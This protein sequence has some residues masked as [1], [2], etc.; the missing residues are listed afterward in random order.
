[1][2]TGVGHF[3][4]ALVMVLAGARAAM[5]QNSD[6]AVIAGY[7][8]FVDAL[9]AGDAGALENLI[10][11]ETL[12]QERSRKIFID[13]ATA[14]KGL[15]KAAVSK[16]GVDGKQFRC[17][18]DLIVSAADRK[19]IAAAKVKY[20][21]GTR[22]A[23]IEKSGEL[24]PMDMRRRQD[25]QWQVILEVPGVESE[26]M[27]SFD[28]SN[29]Y[30]HPGAARQ[31]ALAGIKV[32]RYKAVIEAFIQTRARIESGDLAT[33]AAAAAELTGKLSAAAADAAKAAA[34]L[35]VGRGKD[36]P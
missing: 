28:P 30:L 8:K 23:R 9:E 6:A 32:A 29:P 16:F 5:A 27:D 34:A 4:A 18:F 20:E 11:A 26:E 19:A 3:L 15:E 17:G 10:C 21:E 33:A 2:K 13:L 22:M 36:R 12:P 35:P 25:G 7:L 24:A 1:M 14:Q 31:T